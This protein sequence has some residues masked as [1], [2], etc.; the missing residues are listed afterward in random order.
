MSA[1]GIAVA[2]ALT[3]TPA[4]ADEEE[5]AP[6][7]YYLSLGDSLSTG[8]Q[9]GQG[10]TDQGYPDQLA[11]LLRERTPGLRL[12]KLGCRGETSTTLIKGGTCSYQRASQLAQ[13]LAFL[14]DNPGRVKYVTI[15]IGGNDVNACIK[16]NSPD[17]R[18]VVRNVNALARNLWTITSGLRKAGGPGPS[19]TGMTYYDPV[20]A[21]WLTGSS[22]RRQAKLSVPLV[23]SVN[24]LAWTIYGL[25]GFRVADVAKTFATADF[26]DENGTPRNVARI[27][28]WTYMCERRDIHPNADGYAR[29]AETFAA[30]IP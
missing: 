5:P 29:I 22:G 2:L 3:V 23:Q 16:N 28:R 9:P 21:A 15:D 14:S 1:A 20:L 30:T 19:Y 8:Y 13:A 25:A 10:D 6:E 27:C 18:C 24:G 4:R 11:A 17:P 12:V 26:T 7:L